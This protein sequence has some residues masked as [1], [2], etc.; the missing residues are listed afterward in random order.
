MIN[1]RNRKAAFANIEKKAGPA[2]KP[3]RKP[4]KK[5]LGAAPA[6]KLLGGSYQ[7]RGSP[8]MLPPVQS[9]SM[10]PQSTPT[11]KSNSSGEPPPETGGQSI[12]C[13]YCGHEI[14][15]PPSAPGPTP[16]TT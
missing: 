7:D 9:Q 10:M 12:T 1:A 2:P 14:P 13:P 11:S 16:S 5:N 4:R 3:G 6:D 15:L 8:S